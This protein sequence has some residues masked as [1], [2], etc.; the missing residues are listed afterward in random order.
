MK[1]KYVGV[2]PRYVSEDD[3]GKRDNNASMHVL[4]SI[5][6]KTVACRSNSE[7]CVWRVEAGQGENASMHVWDSEVV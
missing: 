7:V 3:V 6:T 1:K 2:T 5:D 4:N